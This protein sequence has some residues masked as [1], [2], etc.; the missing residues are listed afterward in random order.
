M[1]LSLLS[2]SGKYNCIGPCSNCDR[3][4]RIENWYYWL[5]VDILATGIYLY[6]GIYFYAVLYFVYVFL[7]AEGWREWHKSMNL[8]KK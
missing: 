6:K 1:S 2:S 3:L 7:A 8:E 4:K 5:A